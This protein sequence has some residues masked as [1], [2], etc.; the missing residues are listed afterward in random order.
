MTEKDW[1]VLVVSSSEKGNDFISKHIDS[2]CVVDYANSGAEA[3]QKI[4]EIEY[5]AVLINCP[6]KDE[7]GTEL[8]ENIIMDYYSGVLLFVKSETYDVVSYQMEKIGAFCIA[9]PVS[10]FAFLQGIRLAIASNQRLK[11]LAK[12]TES[13]KDKMEEIKLVGRAKLLLITKLS[14]SEEEAHKYIEKQA[15][16]RCVKKTVIACDIIKNYSD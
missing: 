13:L 3:R 12:K 1:R 10:P 16:D 4:A 2:D 7:F 11:S 5:N 9:K 14:F 8:A 15:M 6:L